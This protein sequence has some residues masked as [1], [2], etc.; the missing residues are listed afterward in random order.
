MLPDRRPELLV[1]ILALLD[2]WYDFDLCELGGG[3]TAYHGF[4]ELYGLI[5]GY[6]RAGNSIGRISMGYVSSRIADAYLTC[7][8]LWRRCRR[9]VV[10]SVGDALLILLTVCP[11]LDYLPEAASAVVVG[12]TGCVVSRTLEPRIPIISHYKLL[13]LTSNQQLT[14]N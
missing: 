14:S 3:L 5:S 4:N 2:D 10:A 1:S 12:R 7:D 6:Y 8:S 13:L 11:A 9:L